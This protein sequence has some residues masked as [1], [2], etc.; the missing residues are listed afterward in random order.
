[1]RTTNVACL[2]RVD[3]DEE[4]GDAEEMAAFE[5]CSLPPPL[6]M[7]LALLALLLDV[8]AIAFFDCS[9]AALPFA[10]PFLTFQYSSLPS[11][12]ERQA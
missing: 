4:D 3:E 1:M 8:Q 11:V 6:V 2:L 12:P 10:S 5:A 9:A 7:L